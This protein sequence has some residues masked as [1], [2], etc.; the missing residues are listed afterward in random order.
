MVK[1]GLDLWFQHEYMVYNLG[2]P[3]FMVDVS[4]VSYR[5]VETQWYA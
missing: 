4:I 2:Q 5:N 1:Y 3:W